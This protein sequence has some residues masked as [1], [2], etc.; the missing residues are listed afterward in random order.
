VELQESEI[1]GPFREKNS[2]KCRFSE[3]IRKNGRRIATSW[4]K[5]LKTV[6]ESPL[7]GLKI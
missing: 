6:E 1:L 5:N 3:Q 4:T 2:K 7:L